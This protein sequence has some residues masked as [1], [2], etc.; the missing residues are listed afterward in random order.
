MGERAQRERIADVEADLLACQTRLAAITRLSS[1]ANPP[2]SKRSRADPPEVATV[3]ERLA[4]E[5]RAQLARILSEPFETRT[6]LPIPPKTRAKRGPIQ[7]AP[8]PKRRASPPL[9]VVVGTRDPTALD[10]LLALLLVPYGGGDPL[11]ALL[12]LLLVPY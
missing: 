5:A 1:I 7:R 12:A 11:D 10:R 4:T 9:L 3:R 2:A 8:K 6:P